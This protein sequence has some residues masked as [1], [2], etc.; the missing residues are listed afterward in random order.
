VQAGSQQITFPMT[1]ASNA[2]FNV[3]TGATLVI[4]GPLTI[5]SGDTI[6]QT[7]AG[8]VLYETPVNLSGGSSLALSGSAIAQSLSLAAGTSAKMAPDSN[9]VLT[10]DSLSMAPGSTLDL[11]TNRLVIDYGAGNASPASAVE[12]ALRS[13]FN[14]GSW[15]GTGLISSSAATNPHYALAYAD[16]NNPADATA[17]SGLQPNEVI[18]QYEL[19]G[20]ADLTGSVDFSDVLTVARNYG[21]SIDA[22]GNPVDWADGDF[23]YDGTVDFE[24]LLDVAENFDQPL[25]PQETAEVGNVFALQWQIA[26]QD[27]NASV[28]EPGALNLGIIGVAGL[29]GCRRIRQGN[30]IL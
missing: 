11:A 26:L 17:I 29:L 5:N 24:D 6:T 22:N 28:P 9:S 14:G 16:G 21:R 27:V 23:N 7:G 13:G 18:V 2:V 1:I 10:V 3:S 4:S 15:T 25:T 19:A 20:D 30:S 8:T 12:A